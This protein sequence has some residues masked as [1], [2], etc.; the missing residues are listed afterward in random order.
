M[1][2]TLVRPGAGQLVL[3]AGN[4]AAT[5]AAFTLFF[6]VLGRL[7]PSRT[8]IVMALEAVA[9][10]AL[11]AVFLDES[12]QPVI[13]LGGVAV[14]AGALLAAAFSP[15]SVEQIESASAP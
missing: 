1:Q 13:A 10:I 8:A 7:G 5:A 9:G 11:S 14:L 15:Q 4:A 2:G 12:V 3:P 6:V